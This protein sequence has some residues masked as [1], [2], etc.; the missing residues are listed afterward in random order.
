MQKET[1]GGVFV[2]ENYETLDVNKDQSQNGRVWLSLHFKIM[3][4]TSSLL[5]I[6]FIFITLLTI[7]SEA[8]YLREQARKRAINSLTSLVTI[9]RQA[10]YANQFS[11]LTSHLARIEHDDD[12]LVRAEIY[13][14]NGK[15]AHFLRPSIISPTDKTITLTRTFFVNNLRFGHVI[16]EYRV[17]HLEVALNRIATLLITGLIAALL[18]VGLTI[19]LAVKHFISLPLGKFIEAADEIADGKL[20]RETGLK[21]RNDEI[22]YLAERFERMVETLKTSLRSVE[23]TNLLLE[24]RV[25]ERTTELGREKKRTEDIIESLADGLITIDNA[26]IVT[27]CNHAA[28]AIGEYEYGTSKGKP[29]NDLLPLK[30]REGKSLYPLN[31]SEDKSTEPVEAFLSVGIKSVPILISCAHLSTES[32]N[33]SGLV[34]TIRDITNIHDLNEQIRRSDRLSSL[35]VLSAGV[36]HEL[37]NPLGNISTYA[38]LTGERIRKNQLPSEEWIE[39]II[40]EARRG[41]TIVSQLL[42][43]SRREPA[44]REVV[45]LTEIAE[46]CKKL[47]STTMKD[48]DIEFSMIA[49][50]GK[51]LATGNINQLQQVVINLLNNAV[52]SFND[53]EPLKKHKKISLSLE[54]SLFPDFQ[55]KISVEDNGCGIKEHIGEQIF[56]PFFTTKDIGKGTGLGLSVTY[57]IIK[58]HGGDISFISTPHKG[59]T[60]NVLLPGATKE[61]DESISM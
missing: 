52:Q 9:A 46:N 3:I 4:I 12:D 40:K 26:N 30:N 29:I 59:S 55:W 47:V 39:T 37:N 45:S 16:I 14:R 36:A 31:I 1:D 35:G 10:Y 41:S 49:P 48:N 20:N 15:L 34:M 5:L 61:S 58:E 21:E 38:Q 8:V 25:K 18:L 23:E 7:K 57:G 6:T 56:N 2:K 24:E 51:C 17:T 33:Y 42:E 32:G 22:G 54:K 13:E 28:A 60:F 11:E 53:E 43:F 27:Y 19:H 44:K 50:S